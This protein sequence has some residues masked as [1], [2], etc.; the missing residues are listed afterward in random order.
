[1]KI[2]GTRTQLW[3]TPLKEGGLYIVDKNFCHAVG[4]SCRLHFAIDVV[5]KIVT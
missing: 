4:L 3:R 1:M 5:F 2:K